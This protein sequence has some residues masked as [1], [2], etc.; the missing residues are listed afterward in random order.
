MPRWGTGPLRRSRGSRGVRTGR[1]SF[2]EF[3]FRTDDPAG[4][5]LV[6]RRPVGQIV[7]GDLLD[8]RGKLLGRCL[9]AAHLAAEPGGLTLGHAEGAAEVDLESFD[10]LARG[11]GDELALEA[12]VGD[13]GAGAGVGA[14]V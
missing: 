3:L 12:D 11:V 5:R 2:D 14:A 6:L 10:L 13:L 4:E 8:V 1:R 9:E 7:A